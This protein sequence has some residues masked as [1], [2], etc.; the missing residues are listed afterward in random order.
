[1]SRE[2]SWWIQRGVLGAVCVLVIGVYGYT[3]HSGAL[4]A[5]S[6]DPADMYYNLLVQGFRTG[7][8][9]LK[10]EVPPGFAQLVNPYD[11]VANGPFQL[12]DL[13]YYR[14]KLYLY[15]GVTPALLLFWP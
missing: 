2:K 14:G 5:S 15:Q 13:S 6:L 10:K 8:L 7:R 1:M 4:A 11:P 9:S 3:A 12:L